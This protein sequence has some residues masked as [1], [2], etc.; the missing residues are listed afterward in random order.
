METLENDGFLRKES[1]VIRFQAY[2][3]RCHVV[4]F[5]G[6]KSMFTS[7]DPWGSPVGLVQPPN[8]TENSPSRLKCMFQYVY[9]P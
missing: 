3:F 4:V 8:W 1:P 2:I 6:G 5:L 9:P 7:T